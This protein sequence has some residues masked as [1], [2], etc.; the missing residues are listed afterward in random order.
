MKKSLVLTIVSLFLVSLITVT[1]LQAMKMPS[2]EL[3]MNASKGKVQ[4]PMYTPVTMPHQLHVQKIG[5]CML[6]HH[7]FNDPKEQFIK[8]TS[9]GCHDQ[10]NAQGKEMNNVNASYFAYHSRGNIKSCIGC[11]ESRK[12]AGNATGPISCTKCHPC[13]QDK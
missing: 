3:T 4:N 5:N 12:K 8:C 1:A 10:L 13:K 7:K 11:H 9:S 2:A 6:C